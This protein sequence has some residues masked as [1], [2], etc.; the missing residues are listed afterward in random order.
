MQ[1]D[2]VMDGADRVAVIENFCALPGETIAY[3]QQFC[4]S[5]GQPPQIFLDRRRKLVKIKCF[6]A[7]Q[8]ADVTDGTDFGQPVEIQMAGMQIGYDIVDTMP[9]AEDIKPQDNNYKFWQ[10]HHHAP[11]Y[12]SLAAVGGEF[13]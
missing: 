12:I 3:G 13:Y 2:T 9:P 11:Q 5:A 7:P 8:N 10:P 6:T 1:V 4:R